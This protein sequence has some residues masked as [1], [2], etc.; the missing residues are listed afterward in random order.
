[1]CGLLVSLVGALVLP[2]LHALL[3]LLQRGE[4]L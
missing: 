3:Q 2:G 4:T 1:M